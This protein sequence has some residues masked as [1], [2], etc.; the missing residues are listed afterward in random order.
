MSSDI[1]TIVAEQSIS[2]LKDEIGSMS[3]SISPNKVLRDA[4]TELDLL[5]K[6]NESSLD[7]KTPLFKAMT[8]FEFENGI[9]LASSV[10]EQYRTFGIDLM[11]KLQVEYKC[12]TTSKLATSEL[13]AINY[14]RTL[15]IQRRI[16]NY[17]ELGTVTELGVKLLELLSKELDRAQRHYLTSVQALQALT[18]PPMQL[19]IRAATAIVGHNQI[20]Q[21][22][23]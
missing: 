10:S 23:Q 20:V 12:D 13:I 8:L 4:Q 17:L 1:K 3:T 21:S 22:K 19:N 11:K 9:L 18:Q 15:E 16:T 7:I 14:I 6:G 2:T 5:K